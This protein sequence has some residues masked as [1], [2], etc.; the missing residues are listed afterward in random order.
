MRLRV[1]ESFNAPSASTEACC[2][3]SGILIAEGFEQG[4]QRLGPVA[5]G[6]AGAAQEGEEPLLQISPFQVQLDPTCHHLVRRLEQSPG[7]RADTA[8][9]IRKAYCISASCGIRSV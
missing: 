6:M 3:R 1:R 4:L 2:R 8:K 5:Q 7:S 9:A